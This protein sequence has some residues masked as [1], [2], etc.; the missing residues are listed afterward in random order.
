MPEFAILGSGM[1]GCGAAHAL[2]AE[3]ISPTVYDKR[4]Y[5]GG[6]T[7]SHRFEE[8]FVIDEGPHISFTKVDR[9][10]ELF[11]NNVDGEYEESVARVNNYWKGHW[12]DHPAQCHLHGLPDELV[13]RIIRDFAAAAHA[14][15]GQI[16]NYE[17]WLRASFGDTFAETFPMQYTKKYHTTVAANMSTDWIGPRLYR[18]S[19]EEVV[20]GALSPAA[21]NVHYI[22]QFRYP[23]R[24]GFVSYLDSFLDQ[25]DLKLNHQLVGLDP[26]AKELR[27]SNG[28]VVGYDEVIS[29]IPLPELIPL[30]KGVP[31]D[32]RE[33][34]ARLA[35][36]ECVAVSVGVNRPDPIDAH[37]TYFYDDDI[38]FTRLS[39]PH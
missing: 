39:T 13:V 38:F 29:S 10:R 7:A 9:I 31:N 25:A 21:P 19:I 11:A 6:H 36:S 22:T 12:I 37:W 8:G 4:P 17:Q 34:A 18:P 14:D 28:V 30:I 23:S 26:L 24:G 2:H 5:H 16:D 27:F 15:D 32:V 3:G 1:A 33:A 35:C 20:R